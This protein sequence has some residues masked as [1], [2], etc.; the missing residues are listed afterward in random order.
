MGGN[1]FTSV[2]ISTLKFKEFSYHSL[3]TYKYTGIEIIDYLEKDYITLTEE[4]EIF[5][6]TRENLKRVV[7]KLL[8]EKTLKV[9]MI[10]DTLL[11]NLAKYNLINLKKRVLALRE[12]KEVKLKKELSEDE[13]LE[14]VFKKEI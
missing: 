9:D 5:R 7:T 8:D 10:N 2:C 6:K 4:E 3:M 1:I 12:P 11:K 14:S 13:I